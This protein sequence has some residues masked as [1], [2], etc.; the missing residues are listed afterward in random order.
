ME[1]KEMLMNFA[2]HIL[3]ASITEEAGFDR[4]TI[5]EAVDAAFDLEE[6]I[7]KRIKQEDVLT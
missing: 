7:S 1:R 4:R 5:E 6:I 3:A 2:A